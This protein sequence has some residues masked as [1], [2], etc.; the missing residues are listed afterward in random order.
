M[1]KISYILCA[2]LL[3]SGTIRADEGMWLL[4]LLNQLNIKSMKEAGLRLNAEDIYDINKSSLKDAI[5]IFGGGCTGE[6]VSAEGLLLTNHHCG[7]GAIHG[8]STVEHN[9][10]QDGF[11]AKNRGEELPAPGLQVTFMERMTDVTKEVLAVLDTCT[12]EQSRS[13]TEARL[14]K[15][16]AERA[17]EESPHFMGRLYSMYGGNQYYFVVYKVYTDVRLVGAPPSSIGKFGAD[18][19]NWIWPRQTCD[20]AMFRIYAGADNQPAAYAPENQ[21]YQ[22]KHFLSVSLKGVQQGDFVMTLGYPGST[23][24]YMTSI[25]VD[26]Q[27]QLTNGIGIEVRT[28]RQNVLLEDMLADPKVQLQ[29]ASKYSG[30]TNAWKKWTGMNE[31][32]KKLNVRARRA[33]EEAVFNNWVQAKKKRREKYGTA[34]RDIE[35]S[36]QGQWDM[37]YVNRYLSEALRN[38]EV[39]A[40]A[41]RLFGRMSADRPVQA[42]NLK[43]QANRFFT[44]YNRATDVKVA[45]AMLKIFAERVSAEYHPTVYQTI[46]NNYSGNIDTYVEDLFAKTLFAE[47]DKVDALIER[48]AE[49]TTREEAWKEVQEDPAWLLGQSV[50]EKSME[51]QQA[52]MPYYG[53][54]ARGHRNLMA[55]M[56]EMK[57]EEAMY[58]DANFSMRLTYGNVLT[59]RPRDGVI[60]DYYTTLLC[61]NPNFL[62]IIM[63]FYSNLMF[64]PLNF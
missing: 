47:Q 9:Y 23:T 11:W 26:R 63:L 22:A 5:V 8:L 14:N 13:A 54:Y 7:Y 34:L 21:P 3:M 62:Y 29:Y 28:I 48:M 37:M 38:I 30:S 17:K 59:Y 44:N 42:E 56:M 32:F 55:G 6:V 36:I 60:Y 24:R 27:E 49:E 45:K 31:T 64:C 46:E 18:T 12:T 10:L 53:Q 20:F 52:I 50:N 16:F 39:S 43:N 25:E 1:K 57:K 41:A 15:D 4:P 19:D 51:Y 2:L 40:F 35:E 61:C 58:P 33:E